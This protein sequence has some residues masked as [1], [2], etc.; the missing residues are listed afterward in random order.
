[1][2]LIS[3]FP[4]LLLV[5]LFR[6]IRERNSSRQ[7]ISPMYEVLM[8][9][10]GNI[11]LNVS[12]NKQRQLKLTF[13]W[14]CIFP[15]YILSILL[16]GTSILF[17]IVRSIELGDVKTQKWLTSVVTGFF[18]SICLTQPLKV[19][20]LIYRTNMIRSFLLGFMFGSILCTFYS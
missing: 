18:S 15:A 20:S 6:R 16:V 3:F 14:W 17:I 10:K 19:C 4:S 13:P 2:E 1:V 7:K 11:V 8:K 12:E 9:T 5:Q